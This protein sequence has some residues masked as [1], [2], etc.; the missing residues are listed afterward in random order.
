[1]QRPAPTGAGIVKA[2][3]YADHA[4]IG[5]RQ[6]SVPFIRK[7]Y[8]LVPVRRLPA[9]GRYRSRARPP[10]LYVRHHAFLI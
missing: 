3:A 5:P 10:D 2:V 8:S 7:V 6:D 1:M 9:T 4:A